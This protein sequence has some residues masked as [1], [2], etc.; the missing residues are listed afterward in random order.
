MALPARIAPR[1][2]RFRWSGWL[3]LVLLFIVSL[4]AVTPRLYASDEIQ[5]FAFLRS[6]W[7]D[8]DLSFENEYRYFYDRGIAR[9][10]GFHETFLE[11]T[12]Q[13]G[14]RLHFGTIGSAL[15]LE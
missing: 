14:R 13:T 2:V 12:T 3:A 1:R 4:P 10:Y 5:Y 15:L 7:F 9:S 8:H 11:L 6:L